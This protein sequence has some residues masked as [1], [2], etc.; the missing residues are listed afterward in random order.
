MIKPILDE[1]SDTRTKDIRT[2]LR[3]RHG[4]TCPKSSLSRARRDILS[5]NPTLVH[6]LGKLADYL[7]K[8]VEKNPGSVSA[9]EISD[10]RF[11]RCFLSLKPWIIRFL[12]GTKL[13]FV[14]GTFLKGLHKGIL[15]RL[16]HWT[17]ITTFSLLQQQSSLLNPK[18][19]GLGFC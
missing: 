15:L 4:V 5:S 3:S 1:N 18:T 13:L 7:T 12:G 11:S 2:I 19:I 9:F 14:D 10:E 6:E 8:I 16:P 17:P